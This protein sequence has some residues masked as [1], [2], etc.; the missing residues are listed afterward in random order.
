MPDDQDLSRNAIDSPKSSKTQFTQGGSP[1]YL[2]IL[3]ALKADN[4]QDVSKP[5][6]SV[7]MMQAQ[8]GRA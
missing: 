1:A 8:Q 7:M 3:E 2:A 6:L 5:N 4:P